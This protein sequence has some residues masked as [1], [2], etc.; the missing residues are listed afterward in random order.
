MFHGR[1]AVGHVAHGQ[2]AVRKERVS[3]LKEVMAAVAPAYG[4]NAVWK[5]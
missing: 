3:V 2:N 1:A 4:Q 5:R